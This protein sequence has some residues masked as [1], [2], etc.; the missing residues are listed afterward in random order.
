V[1]YPRHPHRRAHVL[2]PA[3][4]HPGCPAARTGDGTV[5]VSATG[6][7]VVQQRAPSIS[8]PV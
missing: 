7:A 5:E 1:G 3:D 8:V 2:N 4:L 6:L